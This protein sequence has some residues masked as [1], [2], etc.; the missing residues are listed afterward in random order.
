MTTM[1]EDDKEYLKRATPQELLKLTNG[2]PWQIC[3]AIRV[4]ILQGRLSLSQGIEASWIAEMRK[5]KAAGAPP[6]LNADEIR[7]SLSDR[8]DLTRPC[9]ECGHVRYLPPK[10][11]RRVTFTRVHGFGYHGL[12]GECAEE[13]DLAHAC[14][15]VVR[16]GLRW[17]GRC[18][19]K[20]L[21][22]VRQILV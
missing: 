8:S 18:I 13:F 14:K 17:Q 20:P 3:A 6:S 9:S 15:T 2:I 19:S 1:E 5:W 16:R 11:G 22:S 21:V 12:C 10:G 4:A 7:R